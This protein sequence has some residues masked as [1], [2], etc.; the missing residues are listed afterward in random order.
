MENSYIPEQI[1]SD[2]IDQL[3]TSLAKAQGEMEVARKDKNNPFFKSKY[4]DLEDV[5]SEM[6]EPVQD[7]G[8]F[9][10]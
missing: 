3:A 7:N 5:F 8:D 9:L 1:M 10:K 6:T 4:A 2:Q